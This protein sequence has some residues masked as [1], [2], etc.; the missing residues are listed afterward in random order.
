MGAFVVRAESDGGR[1]PSSRE[2][3]LLVGDGGQD[4]ALRSLMRRFVRVRRER[5]SGAYGSTA[6]TPL[7]GARIRN[8]TWEKKTR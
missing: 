5:V 4:W 6:L 7:P 1:F 8:I 3:G 2:E